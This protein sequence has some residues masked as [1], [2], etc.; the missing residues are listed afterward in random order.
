[1]A[2]DSQP[3]EAV[4]GDQQALQHH[5]SVERKPRT[6]TVGDNDIAPIH[7]LGAFS[8]TFFL[9]PVCNVGLK[10]GAA[11]ERNRAAQIV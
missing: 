7:A 1:M 5:D 3:V 9:R 8:L 6:R 2:S 10:S 11:M 4:I